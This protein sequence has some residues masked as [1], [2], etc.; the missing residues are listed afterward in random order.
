MDRAHYSVSTP[1]LLDGKRLAVVGEESPSS[2][3]GVD[4]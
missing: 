2:D 3:D 4:A 1:A